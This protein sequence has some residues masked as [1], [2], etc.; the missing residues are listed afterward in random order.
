M[1]LDFTGRNVEITPALKAFA[2]EKFQRL[3]RRDNHIT[4]VKI[5][6]H[7]EHLSHIAEATLHLNG[8]ELH[9]SAKDE[10]MY[11]ATDALVDKLMGQITKHKEKHADKH[12]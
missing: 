12:R 11:R 9:A 5:I 6:F 1:Q 10:D 4:H 8:T 7:I 2:E 3:E